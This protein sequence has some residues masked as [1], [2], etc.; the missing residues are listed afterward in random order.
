MDRENE[1][2]NIV[3]KRRKGVTAVERII[4]KLCSVII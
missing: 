2:K 4:R 1:S 3:R